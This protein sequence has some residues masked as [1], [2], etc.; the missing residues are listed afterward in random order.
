MLIERLSRLASERSS[1]RRVELLREITGLFLEGVE[2]HRE[3]ELVLF[4]ELMTR[5]VDDVTEAARSELAERIAD[6]GRA[7]KTLVLRLA[8]DIIDVARPI[9]ER[10][11][12]LTDEDLV[13]I[14]ATRTDDH[15]YAISA[16]QTLSSP[17]T[18]VLVRHGSARVLARVAGHDGAEL[19]P[20]S[21]S[22]LVRQSGDDEL[23]EAAMVARRDRAA[24]DLAALV[25]KLSAAVAE[26]LAA[27]GM[28]ERRSVD[29]QERLK[30]HLAET[31][32]DL[33]DVVTMAA[34]IRNGRAGIEESV[35]TLARGRRSY[36]LGALFG[37]LTDIP[38]Q[39]AIRALQKREVE[40]LLVLCRSLDLSW[41]AV[42]AILEMRSVRA[43][44]AYA[45]SQAMRVLYEA[46]EAQAAERT[47]RLLRVRARAADPA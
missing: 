2:L 3:P 27:L 45:P 42:S 30:R 19:S 44:E 32:R 33:R 34:Q 40:P 10:S 17:V 26:R 16:R 47:V 14:A 7:P 46:L 23:L 39:I 13:G 24:R 36:D 20:E 29:L 6:V 8:G 11:P 9:L 22:T 5:V 21:V 38:R 35:L 31:S 18:D 25:P 28:G 43:R 4:D 12:A 37:I 15:R 41:T 1:E